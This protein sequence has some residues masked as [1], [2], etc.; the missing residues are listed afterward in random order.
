MIRILFVGDGER[1]AATV[2]HLVARILGVSVEAHT[3]HWKSLR[4]NGYPR[5]VLFAARQARDAGAVGLVATVDADKDPQREKLRKLVEGRDA[6]RASY[7]SFPI[8]FGEASPHG[9]AWLL[10][11]DVAVRSALGLD[12]QVKIPTVRQVSSPKETLEELR[13]ECEEGGGNICDVLAAIAQLVDPRRCVRAKETGFHSLQE[14]VRRELGQLAAGCGKECRCG[15]ACAHD[16][17]DV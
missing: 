7:P 3:I 5:K 4:V 1:D 17:E 14:E 8:A 16:P 11:D 13:R 9:E 15:D 12:P 6:D 2:P 10:D